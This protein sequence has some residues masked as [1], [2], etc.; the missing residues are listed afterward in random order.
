MS[1]LMLRE[2][3]R[4]FTLADE[5]WLLVQSCQWLMRMYSRIEIAKFAAYEH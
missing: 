4:S 5:S 3:C 1:T 2:F